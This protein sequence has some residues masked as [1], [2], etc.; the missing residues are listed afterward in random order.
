M[1]VEAMLAATSLIDMRLC[2]IPM[3]QMLWAEEDSTILDAQL[4]EARMVAV[5]KKMDVI[6]Q[7]SQSDTYSKRVELFEGNMMKACLLLL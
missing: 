5:Q 1:K 7:S 3:P 2:T 6:Y 4:R